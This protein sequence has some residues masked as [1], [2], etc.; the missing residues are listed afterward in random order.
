M[1]DIYEWRSANP[2]AWAAEQEAE[3][4]AIAAHHPERERMLAMPSMRER[5]H[6]SIGRSRNCSSGMTPIP[7]MPA[8][9]GILEAL[10]QVVTRRE[11]LANSGQKEPVLA[12][13]RLCRTIKFM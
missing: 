4:R 1:Q 11:A 2:E 6:N 12:N 3:R 9:V 5:P 10:E 8:G 7:K 13:T